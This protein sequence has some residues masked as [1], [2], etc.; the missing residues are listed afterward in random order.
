MLGAEISGRFA[1]PPNSLSY[2][3]T[4]GFRAALAAFAVCRTKRNRMALEASLRHFKA[5]YAYL[6][7]IARASGK[8]PFDAKVSEALWIGNSL[9]QKVRREDMQKLIVREFSGP[10]LLPGEKALKLA[11][12]LPEGVLPHHSFHALYLHTITGVIRPNLQ[13]ADSCMVHWGKAVRVGGAARHSGQG[14]KAGDAGRPGAGSFAI[15]QSQR[16]VRKKGK[17][18]LI[19]CRRKL[20]LS[21]AGISLLPSLRA[22]ELVASHWGIA[23]LKLSR[24][25]ARQLESVT[26]RNIYALNQ[27]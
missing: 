8:Q 18:A 26:R 23:V 12:S 4:K 3:G 5:H 10:G 1:L 14:Q 6:R 9:L 16:L 7:L 22:G 17:L 19:A 24:S 27:G 20:K 13:N 25:Q 21:C 2:C 11:G 15:V